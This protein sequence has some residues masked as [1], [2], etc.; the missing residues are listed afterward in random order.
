MRSFFFLIETDIVGV[1]WSFQPLPDAL[2]AVEDEREI[3]IASAIPSGMME[4]PEAQVTAVTSF[5]Y[6]NPNLTSD[7]PSPLFAGDPAIDDDDDKTTPDAL[8]VFSADVGL[9]NEPLQ[10]AG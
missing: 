10:F 1:F 5:L 3:G 2:P 4:N 6:S 8:R 9:N 7:P